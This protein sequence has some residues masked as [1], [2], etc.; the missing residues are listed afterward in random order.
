MIFIG[1]VDGVMIKMVIGA[2]VGVVVVWSVWWSAAGPQRTPLPQ[3]NTL[4]W[5]EIFDPI[6]PS[7]PHARCLKCTNTSSLSLSRSLAR[8][9]SLSLSVV[10]GPAT[11]TWAVM[12][13][14]LAATGRRVS[15]TG[16]LRNPDATCGVAEHVDAWQVG[17]HCD[18]RGLDLW[19]SSLTCGIQRPSELFLEQKRRRIF[20]GQVANIEQ[21]AGPFEAPQWGRL[22]RTSATTHGKS[23]VGAFA[24]LQIVAVV[25]HWCCT[26]LI[27]RQGHTECA[28][29]TDSSC[30]TSSGEMHAVSC[31]CGGGDWP[32]CND[33]T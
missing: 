31:P 26:R 10:V 24:A 33:R 28:G 1:M 11:P 13:V 5:G 22:A 8:A 4:F 25:L 6:P 7:L 20:P 18:R 14:V 3:S 27:S 9:L 17:Q 16:P 12:R 21:K 29:L 2:V 23:A 15:R 19:A 30:P 32:G